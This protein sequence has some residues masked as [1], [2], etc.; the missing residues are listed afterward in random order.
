MISWER[1]D[2][3]REEIGPEDFDEVIEIFLEEVDAA[4]EKLQASGGTTDLEGTMHFLKG[5]A[6]NIGFDEMSRLCQAGETAASRGQNDSIDVRDVIQSYDR[7]K[8]ALL[9][10][11]RAGL[12]A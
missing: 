9:E 10:Q 2:E 12:P 7:A 6:L 4:V 3:L 11:L 5:S 8:A 1:V